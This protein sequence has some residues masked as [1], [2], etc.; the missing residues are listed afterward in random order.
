MEYRRVCFFA[1][2]VF[3][4][5]II[6]AQET[7]S[8]QLQSQSTSLTLKHSGTLY[9]K[10]IYE[11][12]PF[13]QNL[14]GEHGAYGNGTYGD[15]K[16]SY[17]LAVPNNEIANQQPQTRYLFKLNYNDNIKFSFGDVNPNYHKYILPGSRVRGFEVNL[18]IFDEAVNLDI[19][20]GT[21]RKSID[22]YLSNSI[23]LKEALAEGQLTHN[24]SVRFF[25]SGTY[26]RNLTGV[27]LHFGSGDKFNFGLM[28]MNSRDDT[29]SIQQKFTIDE[30]GRKVIDG[31]TP[32]DNIVLGSNIIWKFFDRKLTLFA[33]AALSSITED[34]RGGALSNEDLRDLLDENDE[35]ITFNPRDYD[36]LF[37]LNSTT[38]PIPFTD[39]GFDFDILNSAMS[40][41]TGIRWNLNTSGFR[42]RLEF[43]FQRIGNNY[44]SFGR[45]N[46]VSNFK[47]IRINE[48]IG[49]LQNRL[50]LNMSYSRKE[51]NLNNFKPEPTV[52]NGFNL[53][54]NF[55]YDPNLPGLSFTF[56]STSANNDSP[57]GAGFDQESNSLLLG[58]STFYN[59]SLTSFKNT[60]NF[61]FNRMSFDFTSSSLIDASGNQLTNE[62]VSNSTNISLT[63]QYQNLPFSTRIRYGNN[64][65]VKGAGPSQFLI[66]FGITYN[67]IKNFLRANV[68][69]GYQKIEAGS[70]ESSSLN[71]RFGSNIRIS[72]NQS[73]DIGGFYR[74]D[75]AKSHSRFTLNYRL[76]Y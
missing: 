19:V 70:N 28:F 17:K 72:A 63:T 36:N 74:K 27:R 22:P 45:F 48:N 20:H 14:T 57:A 65:L 59:F 13:K 69:A 1:I 4:P 6:L 25:A 40:Y 3:L 64:S 56:N 34:I 42:N 53:M 66:G 50:N 71:L 43:V 29:N 55:N 16:F 24:D 37:I 61:T 12:V 8:I 5:G 31:V 75:I 47:E 51:D 46:T 33:N 9:S 21:T 62:T 30:L 41:D 76:N 73:I 2:Y 7:S 32:M 60:L 58:I 49:L 26:E 38:K 10:N 18:S 44:Q 68:D 11:E 54:L 35:D 52:N 23:G 39:S 15:F 67:L